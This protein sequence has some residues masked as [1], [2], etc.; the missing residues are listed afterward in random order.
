MKSASISEIKAHLAQ[1]LRVARRGGEVQILERGVPIARLV[2]CPGQV[3]R[4]DKDRLERLV[5]EGIL[6]QGSASLEWILNEP[7]LVAP[8]AQ[9]T[10]AVLEERDDR[11]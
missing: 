5:R 2:G 3:A 7:P 4:G 1:F 10:Q 6:R 8:K 11:L 9:L